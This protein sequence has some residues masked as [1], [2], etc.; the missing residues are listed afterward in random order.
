MNIS[1]REKFLHN[2][3]KV[4]KSGKTININLDISALDMMCLY[5][6]SNNRNIQRSHFINLRN[7]MSIINMDNYALDVEKMKRIEFINKG[8]NARLNLGLNEPSI[9]LKEINGGFIGEQL[10]D[11]DL[12]SNKL[13][14]Q[15]LAWINNMVSESLKYSFIY[16]DIDQLLEIATRFKSEQYGSRASIVK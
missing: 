10:I 5:I 9:I 11:I 3:S 15:E 13:S 12:D 7:L 4:N 2:N 16:N 6:L 14:N 8:L 1:R